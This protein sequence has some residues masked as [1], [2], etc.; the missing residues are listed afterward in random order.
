MFKPRE[1]ASFNVWTPTARRETNA[2][3]YLCCCEQVLSYCSRAVD[4]GGMSVAIGCHR[5]T[6]HHSSRRILLM[7]S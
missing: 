1:I 3:K 5:T 7:R 2:Y 6:E 4:E